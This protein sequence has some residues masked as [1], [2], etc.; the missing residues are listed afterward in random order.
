MGSNIE[1]EKKH[2]FWEH[3]SR[4]HR[5]RAGGPIAPLTHLLGRRHL[6]RHSLVAR[7]A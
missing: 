4:E 7:T 2:M 6:H 5:R 1:K 3:H